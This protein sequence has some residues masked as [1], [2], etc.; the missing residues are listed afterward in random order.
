MHVAASS[1]LK[2]KGMP[3]QDHADYV[4]EL[5]VRQADWHGFTVHSVKDSVTSDESD[6]LGF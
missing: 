5:R 6:R 3:G 1:V 2:F 4:S